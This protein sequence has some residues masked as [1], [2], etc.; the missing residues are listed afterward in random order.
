MSD[1]PPLVGSVWR[2]SL[3]HHYVYVVRSVRIAPVAGWYVWVQ[4]RSTPF[5]KKEWEAARM[6]PVERV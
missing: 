4:E 5:R 3:G 2:S 1:M 6:R